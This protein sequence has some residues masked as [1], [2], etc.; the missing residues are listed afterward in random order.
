MAGVEFFGADLAQEQHF[1]SFILENTCKCFKDSMDERFF[2][3]K[4]TQSKT[5]I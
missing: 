5:A 2:N 3:Q 4:D 1:H